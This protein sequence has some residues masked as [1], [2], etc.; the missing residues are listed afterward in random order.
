M[1]HTAQ[2]GEDERLALRSGKVADI[3]D[4]RAQ[5]GAGVDQG[6]SLGGAERFGELNVLGRADA[7]HRK[8]AVAG[9][10]VKPGPDLAR[11]LAVVPQ[12]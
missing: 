3:R 2:L 10:S 9:D 6:A 1:R 4:Q 11:Q 7:Q 5:L 12:V 8:T